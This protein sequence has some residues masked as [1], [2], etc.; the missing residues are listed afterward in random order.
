MLPNL[1]FP[2]TAAAGRRSSL[3]HRLFC[4][5]PDVRT[6]TSLSSIIILDKRA[7]AVA[8]DY[9]GLVKAVR[10]QTLR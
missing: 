3:S 7:K 6:L 1:S 10:V 4:E 9:K 2:Y 8:D 5:V